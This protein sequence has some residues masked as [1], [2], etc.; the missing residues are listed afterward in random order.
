M[1]RIAPL[2]PEQTPAAAQPMLDAVK[3]KMGKVPN[4]FRTMAHAPAALSAYL[5][6]SGA[7]SHGVLT[8]AEREIVALAVG[9]ANACGYCLSAHTLG[10]KAAGLS[11]E[12]I[13][14]ARAG[15]GSAIATFA[16]KVVQARGLLSDDDVATARAMGLSDAQIVEVVAGVALQTFTNYLN[17]IAATDIDFPVVQV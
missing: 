7:L 10:G 13:A 17:H 5:Q 1:P 4:L 3:A 8:A 15:Q 2:T 16:Q 6:F 11:P 14:A 12:A 9:Q